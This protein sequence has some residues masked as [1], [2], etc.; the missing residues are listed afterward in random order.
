MSRVFHGLLLAALLIFVGFRVYGHFAT[1]QTEFGS[2]NR[3]L[4]SQ[5]IKSIRETADDA[6]RKHDW[7]V[8]SEAQAKIVDDDPKSVQAWVRLA[9]SQHQAGQYEQALA[10]FMHLC[11]FEGDY[12][13]WALYNI[14]CVYALQGENRLAL[15]YL[16]E[17]ADAGYRTRTSISEDPDLQS[18]VDDPEFHRLAEFLKPVSLR[19]I[20]RRL[21]FL[22]GRWNMLGDREQ[23]VGTMQLTAAGGGYALR[24]E[25]VDSSRSDTWTIF[26]YYE[27]EIQNWK[28]LWL[29]ERGNVLH[30]QGSE[31]EEE[32]LVFEGYL[33][34]ADG[35]RKQARATYAEQDSERIHLALAWT[36]DA[37]TT[38]ESLL[39]A[40]LVS[41]NPARG[42]HEPDFPSG[43][44]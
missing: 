27:P 40:T 26:A 1:T 25:C 38:W 18:L 44:L 32:T 34:A 9:Y 12:R 20:F 6:F 23:R 39:E 28:Q 3:P 35:Q 16:A 41:L 15:S 24:G 30:L 33:T 2:E 4:S 19:N 31:S 17:A 7:A 29:D 5:E 21:D 37:G 13:C 42:S 36:P 8:A 10:S 11:K 14:A 43:R 22:L